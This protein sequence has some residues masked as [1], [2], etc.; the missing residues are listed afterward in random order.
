MDQPVVRH[1]LAKAGAEL[2]SLSA[3]IEQFLYQLKTLKKDD[4]DVQLGGLMALA[5]AKAGMVLN[6]CA[7]VA[8]L[9]FGGNGY[10]RT[11]KGEIA[12]SMLSILFHIILC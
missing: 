3:W 5:K 4:A 12:E 10:T 2:E 8:V 6:E 1:R 11:G 9:L 7:Q